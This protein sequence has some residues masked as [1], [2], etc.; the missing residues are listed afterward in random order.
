MT[1]TI[2]PYRLFRVEVRRRQR[3]S[4]SFLRITVTGADLDGFADNGYDQRIKLMLPLPGHGLP[5]LPDTDWFGH[6]RALPDERRSPIRTYTVRHV[7]PAAREVDVDIV[8][9]QGTGPAARWAETAGP[10]DEVALVGPVAGYPGHHGGIEFRPPEGTRTVLLAGDETAVPAICG[11]LE[12]L[13]AGMAG[14]ALLE[15]P[16]PADT[17]PVTAPLGVRVS[18][19]ARDGAPH[20]GRLVPAVEAAATRL[21]PPAAGGDPLDDIDVDN[22]LLWEVPE[23]AAAGCYAWLAG[24]AS[25]IKALRRLLVT[26]HGL[27]RRAVAFMGYWRLGRAESA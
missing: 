20:G 4:P 22:E 27:D 13:P 18:W 14:E 23:D 8:D 5:D 2:A 11:I 19:L 9:H 15:V 24:E 17:L 16:D 25:V 7:R 3:L 6:W 26:E 21:L 12:R 1:T 10:G